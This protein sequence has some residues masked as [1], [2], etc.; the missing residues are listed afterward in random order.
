MKGNVYC[1]GGSRGNFSTDTS[2]DATM[3]MLDLSQSATMAQLANN[4]TLIQPNTNGVTV[5]SRKCPQV[6]QITDSEIIYSGGYGSSAND[7]PILDQTIAYSAETNSW[8]KYPNY[9][10]APYGNR[11]MYI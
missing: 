6:A 8:S 3:Y 1:F 2:T 7:N 10:E 9:V 11:Q 5:D 4:W